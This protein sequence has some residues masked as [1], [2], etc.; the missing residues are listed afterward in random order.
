MARAPA[1]RLT[2][3]QKEEI[4]KAVHETDLKAQ[5]VA[6]AMRINPGTAHYW[7]GKFRHKKVRAKED[8]IPKQVAAPTPRKRDADYYRAAAAFFD[9]IYVK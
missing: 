4:K 9:T 8:F 2:R 3:E 1:V 6:T 7:F 5:E